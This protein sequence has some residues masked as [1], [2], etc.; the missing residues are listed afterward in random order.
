VTLSALPILWLLGWGTLAGLD[1]VSVLQGLLSRPLV[2]GPIAGLVLGDV[3]AGLKIGTILELFALDVVPVG[4][5]R[6]PD[7]GAATVGAVVYGAGTE[8]PVTLGASVGL[9]LAF[10]IGLGTTIPAVRRLN[11]RTIRANADRIAAGDAAAVRAVHLTCLGHD[12]V[13]SI[14]VATVAL[15]ASA[16]LTRFRP[17]PLLGHQLTLAAVI[18]ATWALAHGAAASAR[19]GPR[20]RW[21]VL[22]AVVGFGG[23]LL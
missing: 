23:T 11:A 13:R 22:G 8:W 3:E 14:V 7:F 5:S 1:L 9:G 15:V 10:A 17:G 21:A 12:I 4:A 2:I 18:G 6:Y 20:W 16:L 19:S